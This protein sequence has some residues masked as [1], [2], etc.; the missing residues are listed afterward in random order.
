MLQ[1]WIGVH[2]LYKRVFDILYT[3][4][5]SLTA[6]YCTHGTNVEK[7]TGYKCDTAHDQSLVFYV[8]CQT[9]YTPKIF[10]KTHFWVV[11]RHT[12]YVICHFCAPNRLCRRKK[13]MPFS[14]DIVQGYIWAGSS[15]HTGPD[16]FER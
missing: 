1:A 16:N 13:I 9:L 11:T 3:S 14:V 10:R 4:A 12:F 5:H 8:F 2:V 7:P 15:S 6:H